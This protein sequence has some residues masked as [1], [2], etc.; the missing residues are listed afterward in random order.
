MLAATMATLNL[1][2]KFVEIGKRDIWSAQRV[3]VERPD[4]RYSLVA[5]DFL[6]VQVR[7]V[8]RSHADQR[9]M[10]LPKLSCW[11]AAKFCNRAPTHPF[12]QP[13]SMFAG[14]QHRPPRG[15]DHAGEQ[16][17]RPTADPGV[18]IL[19][20]P[21]SV[22]PVFPSAAHWEGCYELALPWW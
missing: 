1:N 15:R 22:A 4:V 20:H 7:G 18:L 5:I 10:P 9:S 14:P 3:A 11:L 17:S 21:S 6:P 8:S 19:G 2:G 13:W 12:W 16:S